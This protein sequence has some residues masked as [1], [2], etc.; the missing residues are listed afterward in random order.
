VKTFG[1]FLVDTLLLTGAAFLA[2]KFLWTFLAVETVAGAVTLT[3][4]I[5][6]KRWQ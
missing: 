2:W 6:E 1:T 3:L 4:R 5:V